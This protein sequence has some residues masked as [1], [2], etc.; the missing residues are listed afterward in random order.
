MGEDEGGRLMSSMMPKDAAGFLE[1]FISPSNVKPVSGD[2]IK[3]PSS[4]DN[5]VFDSI[6]AA[7]GLDLMVRVMAMTSL[8]HVFWSTD[9]WTAADI[10][11]EERADWGS[12]SRD[13][14]EDDEESAGC[15]GG[16]ALTT[17]TPRSP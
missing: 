4:S 6:S 14:G 8:T 13:A 17:Q 11:H 2:D 16:V 1:M 5:S 10:A 15:L 7:A 12:S 9:D 3:P